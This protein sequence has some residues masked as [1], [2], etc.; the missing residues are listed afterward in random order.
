MTRMMIGCILLVTTFVFDAPAFAQCF[1]IPRNHRC[2]KIYC[3]SHP[4]GYGRIALSNKGRSAVVRL[5]PGKSAN[6]T[7]KINADHEN[8]IFICDITDQSGIPS[9][10]TARGSW[11]N[12]EKT[13]V[14][15]RNYSELENDK[16][17]RFEITNDSNRT[18]IFAISAWHKNSKPSA[19]MPWLLSHGELIR[20]VV[21]EDKTHLTFIWDDSYNS[22]NPN[23]QLDHNVILKIVK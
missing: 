14:R 17:K 19:T 20:K 13:G 2:C 21:V 12:P 3:D 1:C 8:G 15:Y 16:E 4:N 22:S 6:L 7:V 18:K 23:E 11:C 5:R 9:G 10:D